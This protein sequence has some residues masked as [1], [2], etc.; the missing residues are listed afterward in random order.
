MIMFIYGLF[1]TGASVSGL[2]CLTGASTVSG[3][4][5]L[6]TFEIAAELQ[7]QVDLGTR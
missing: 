3:L 2:D 5:C 4:D 7:V 6:F 1:P